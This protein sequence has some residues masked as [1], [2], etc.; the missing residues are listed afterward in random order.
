MDLEIGSVLQNR[1][2]VVRLI[3]QGGFRK[4]YRAWDM[5]LAR[6]VALKE[7]LDADPELQRQFERE[8][9]QLAT[10]RHPNLPIIFDYFTLP[11]GRQ[12]LIVDLVEGQNLDD[13]MRERGGRLSETEALAAIRQVADAVN[14]LHTRKPPIIHCSIKPSKI[15]IADNRFLLM[16]SGVSQN[17]DNDSRT[18][19]GVKTVSPPF[20]AP[21][22][23]TGLVE[24]RSD[25]YSL[26]ATL[27]NLL[28][29]RQPP[30]A[31]NLSSGAKTLTPPQKI[32]PDI[33][34]AT[35][36]AVVAAMAT[37]AAERL[38]SAV[39]F[40]EALAG[41]P[42]P[43]LMPPHPA[44]VLEFITATFNMEDLKTLCFQLSVSF[45]DLSASNRVG[46]AR[47]LI[48]Y[49]QNRGR[50][51]DLMVALARERPQQY[52]GKFGSP[53]RQ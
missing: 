47:D 18:T 7:S 13:L 51:H 10:L 14:Y 33:S 8:A 4:V 21:E 25:V 2:R 15:V 39:A 40:A 3:G 34:E 41:P 43:K 28:T 1:Y 32:N 24:P 29:G 6:P 35:S 19:E 42:P 48:E 46:K 16:D 52:Q 49:L 11:G 5:A 31:P 36:Q 45:D 17:Y 53:P 27:Y 37:D 50:L 20:S 38:A 30:E 26:G 22:Q 12:F 9:R 44:D 23:Y